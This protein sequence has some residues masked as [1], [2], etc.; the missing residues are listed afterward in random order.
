MD[1]RDC[2]MT[3]LTRQMGGVAQQ[4]FCWLITRVWSLLFWPLSQRI[5]PFPFVKRIFENEQ[6]LPLELQGGMSTIQQGLLQ[7]R[8]QN[9]FP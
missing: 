4:L 9:S 2:V 7:L 5:R 1:S 6:Q 8:Q 3:H